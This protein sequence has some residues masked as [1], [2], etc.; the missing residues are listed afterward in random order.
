MNIERGRLFLVVG[1]SGSGKD[2]LLAETL[3]RWP[4]SARPLRC[5]RRYIT[6]PAHPSEPFVSVTTEEFEDLERRGKFCMSWHV[7]GT[8]YGVPAT[9]LDWL[10]QGQH[11]IVNVSRE[12]IARVRR[13]I[14]ATKV[15]FVKVPFKITRRRMQARR[16]EAENDPSFQQRLLRARDNPALT[17]A[18]MVIDNSGPLD[19]AAAEMLRYLLSYEN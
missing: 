16:R 19:A 15:I 7:Y 14:P 18:D 17:D 8:H 3:R 10:E 6:R 13:E 1:N 2:A 9:L 11:V 12:I 5:P 4:D